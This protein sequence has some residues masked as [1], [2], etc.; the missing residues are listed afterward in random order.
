MQH[1]L[2]R[3]VWVRLAHLAADIED[4]QALQALAPLS[5]PFLPWTDFSL[6]PTAILAI[7]GDIVISERRVIVEC[8]SGNSTIFAARA[9]SQQ[10]IDGHVYSLDHLPAW[11]TVTTRAIVGEGLT[12]WASVTC[13]PLVDGWYDK[14]ILPAI[15]GID[16]LVVDGPP[17]FERA[18]ETARQPALDF[19][20][21]RLAPG[22]TIVLD[23]CRRRGEKRVMAVWR[24]RYG[25]EFR[26]QRGGYASARVPGEPSKVDSGTA[27]AVLA[28][29][30]AGAT[31]P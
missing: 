4:A 30:A 3:K 2:P 25:V 6:R 28:G 8:G 18:T 12:R 11:A 17:A 20:W 5:G 9:L 23:D 10:G 1:S 21:D 22:A 7:V 24:E 26:Y 29:G 27:G 31:T 13:A 14:A 15:E 16:L 19:F